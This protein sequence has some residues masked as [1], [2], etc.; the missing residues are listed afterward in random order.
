MQQFLNRVQN[1]QESYSSKDFTLRS[2]CMDSEELRDLFIEGPGGVQ[3]RRNTDITKVPN[4]NYMIVST[5]SFRI[6]KL[7]Y[8]VS[9]LSIS[10]FLFCLN[11]LLFYNA[12]FHNGFIISNCKSHVA[13][14]ISVQTKVAK[15]V[16]TNS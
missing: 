2:S 13:D 5:S 12:K 3:K 10:I 14:K 11:I 6:R 16:Y 4:Y 8:N 9:W 7:F 15:L 1:M